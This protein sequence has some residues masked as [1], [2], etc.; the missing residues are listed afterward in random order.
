MNMY[1]INILQPLNFFNTQG[2][3]R[4]TNKTN[5]SM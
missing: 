2:W 1:Y 5:F 4:K 3:S